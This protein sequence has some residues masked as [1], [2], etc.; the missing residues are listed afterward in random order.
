ML[1]GDFLMLARFL[2]LTKSQE[3]MAFTSGNEGDGR[4]SGEQARDS[5]GSNA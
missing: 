2:A 3:I 1:L 4:E 5:G